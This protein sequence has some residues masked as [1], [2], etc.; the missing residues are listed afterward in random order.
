[1]PI[2]S[3]LPGL[4][5]SA[6]TLKYLAIIAMTIDHIALLFVPADSSLYAVMR[7]IGR[8]TAPIMS[9]FIAEGFRYT[10]NYWAYIRRL[11]VFA[12]ISQPVYFIMLF[13]R[14]PNNATEFLMHLN[15]MYTFI[16][17]LLILK[18]INTDKIN[19]CGKIALCI[20]CLILSMFGDWIYFIPAWVLIFHWFRNDYKKKAALFSIIAVFS[21]FQFGVLQLGTLLALIPLNMY[22]GER[23]AGGNKVVNKWIFYLFY[24]LH[25][26]ILILIKHFI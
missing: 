4:K 14:S 2:I 18:V 1:M 8:L 17:S 15:V 20:L 16:I 25:I 22:S 24:P 3:K 7:I 12:V 11:A 23:G 5:F 19:V 10:R 6:N 9:F 13:G 26:L 21:C